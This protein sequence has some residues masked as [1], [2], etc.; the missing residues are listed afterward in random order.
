MANMKANTDK[1]L[2]ALGLGAEWGACNAGL[3]S[4]G[5]YLRVPTHLTH[6]L[7][8]NGKYLIAYCEGNILLLIK[9]DGLSHVHE[10][11]K[12]AQE[13][14]AKLCRLEGA[15]QAREQARLEKTE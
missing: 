4:G 13:A 7:A 9:P 11:I 8:M 5:L 10:K 3:K 15:E 12:M 6:K 2:E 14:Y 1:V